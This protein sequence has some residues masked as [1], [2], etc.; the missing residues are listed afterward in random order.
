MFYNLWVYFCLSYAAPWT[1]SACRPVSSTLENGLLFLCV[2]IFLPFLSF[3]SL[4]ILFSGHWSFISLT[5]LSY[6]SSLYPC[7]LCSD[8]FSVLSSFKQ[9][10]NSE[11]FIQGE[12]FEL[13]VRSV[14]VYRLVA[15]NISFF[16]SSQFSLQSNL[17][18]AWLAV[19]TRSFTVLG[20]G[21]YLKRRIKTYAHCHCWK[22]SSKFDKNK[23][24][25]ALVAWG[26]R[27]S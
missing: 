23:E 8:F 10:T 27:F 13:R 6:Y 16:S 22:I 9:T 21:F 24:H 26:C 5:F 14:G 15:W 3:S 2:F 4:E 20:A 7:C 12:L 17:I 18:R 25:T 19:K 11:V 1:L